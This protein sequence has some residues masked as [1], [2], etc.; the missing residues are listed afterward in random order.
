MSTHYIPLSV[1]ESCDITCVITIRDVRSS[2]R[3]VDLEMMRRLHRKVNI[4]VVIAK[5]DSLTAAEVKRLKV[6][7]LS[8]LEEHQIQVP[9]IIFPSRKYRWTYIQK[10]NTHEHRTSSFFSSR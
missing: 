6:R 10:Y 7:I 2:L 3:Q 1:S 5:A 9:Y 4:V 8:D